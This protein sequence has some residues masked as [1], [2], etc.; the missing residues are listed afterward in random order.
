M[1][2]KKATA[3][4]LSDNSKALLIFYFVIFAVM[5]SFILRTTLFTSSNYG[6]LGGLDA[7]SMIF[8]FVVSLIF[9]ESFKMLQQNG[10]SRKTIFLS[11]VYSTIILAVVM[12]VVDSLTAMLMDIITSNYESGFFQIYQARYQSMRSAQHFFEGLLWYVT[13]YVMM[14]AI[15]FFIT[16]L[17][18]RMGKL[19]KVLVSVGVPVF[20][21]IILPILSNLTGGAIYE[22]IKNFF[23]FAWGF[24]HGF[25]P[26]FSMVSASIFSVI[27]GGLAFLLIRRAVPKQ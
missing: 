2:L 8:I 21:V 11:F 9:A 15:G 7:S 24:S 27:L 13:A 17:Y 10:C 18:Y 25:N 23:D 3:Y 16:N 20:F 22:G 12:A 14:G 19:L 5:L 1:T 26:Y 6:T 4:R